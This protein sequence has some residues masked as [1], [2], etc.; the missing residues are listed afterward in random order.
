M[1]KLLFLFI[2]LFLNNQL[3]SQCWSQVSNGQNHT[4]A[5]KTDGTLWA[6]G[7]NLFGQLGNGNNT[8]SNF[9]IQI[10][11][12]ND[13]RQVAA[14]GAHSLAIKNDGTLW[15][16]GYN[17]NGQVGNNSIIDVNIPTRIG[18]ENDWKDVFGGVY[19]SAAIKNN[20]TLWGWGLNYYNWQ[21]AQPFSNSDILVPT[22]IGTDMD[23]KSIS[24]GAF[25]TIALKNNNSLWSWGQSNFGELGNGILISQI[26]FPT[27][28]GSS[29]DWKEI[30]TG[31][32]FTM[33]I[34]NNGTLWSWG[35]GYSSIPL[36]NGTSSDWSKISSYGN[37]NLAIKSNGSLWS[38]GNNS[39]GQLGNGNNTN[40]TFPTQIGNE[41]NWTKLSNGIRSSSVVNSSSE[42]K[43]FGQNNVGQLGIGSNI[44]SFVP[45]PV[46]CINLGLEDNITDYFG[47]FPN[48]ATDY[49][50]IKNILN[51]DVKNITIF[52][53]NGK[54]IINI[55]S[56]NSIIEINS[57][58]KGLYIV[59]VETINNTFNYKLSKQ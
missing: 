38:W 28:I 26:F 55:S 27:Q 1:K 53:M 33:A 4:I 25:S 12:S 8:D 51:L 50:N 19:V 22:Q 59:R 48:P 39:N 29:T 58:P 45:V 44:D 41:T 42:L 9:P 15:A 57:I 2:L 23:W 20:F 11:T 35:L 13:W 3:Y 56:N 18:N 40:I 16:W 6:W 24:F 5:I 30:S 14:G 46:N 43:T 54:Q 47:I 31:F 21:L 37:F 49:L 34:K 17:L 52:D 10:G 36:Q 32:N 7:S